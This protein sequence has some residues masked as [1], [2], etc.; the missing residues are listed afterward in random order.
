MARR[1]QNNSTS[2]ISESQLV[3]WSFTKCVVR[4]YSKCECEAETEATSDAIADLVNLEFFV[5]QVLQM[6]ETGGAGDDT[7][8]L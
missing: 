3:G 4:T 5:G 7:P 1:L 8:K 6:S 2:R